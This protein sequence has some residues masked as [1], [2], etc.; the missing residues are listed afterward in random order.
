M[1]KKLH[2][3]NFKCFDN[4][5]IPLK[6]LT[7]LAGANGS[8]KSTVIQSILLV[9]QSYKRYNN[10]NKVIVSGEYIKMGKSNDLLFEN[11][12]DDSIGIKIEY[13]NQRETD[14]ILEYIGNESVLFNKIN[15]PVDEDMNCIFSDR[16]EY[17]AAER[18]GPE[19]IYIGISDTFNLGIHGEYTMCYLSNK[20]QD[21]VQ[22]ELCIEE[23][24]NNLTSQ[25]D[26][27]IKR[28]FTGFSFR[29]DDIVKADAISL[30]FQE[31]SKA[32]KSNE[33][34]PINVGF[35]IT[36]ILPIIVALLKA[37]KGDL[38]II[39]N[40]ECHL[41][42]KAQ[43]VIGELIAKTANIGVQVIV[44]TH[45]DHVLN[46]VRLSVKNSLISNENVQ[47]LFAD[48]ENVGSHY[49]TNI[50]NPVIQ[51]DGS[52]DVWPEGFFDEWD[53]A[54]FDLLG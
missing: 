33:R 48:R 31:V 28:L 27:W 41:H 11:T 49:H 5:E 17:I 8:G 14:V 36:Y 10:L 24:P 37:R 42:P 18:I 20:G 6:N 16:F 3:L 38:V 1:I 52:L 29:I 50:Y 2:L 15:T 44:E 7:L 12:E 22:K 21:I 47:I 45:S 53:N 30:R 34:R 54:L 25:V 26:G 23:Y 32:D 35:G 19:N 9:K 46:G 51:K 13:D 40:P 4:I 43:R 39:E